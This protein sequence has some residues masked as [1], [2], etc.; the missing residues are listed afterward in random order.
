M[1][2]CATTEV[3]RIFPLATGSMPAG[4]PYLEEGLE[5]TQPYRTCCDPHSPQSWLSTEL[6]VSG[7]SC[8]WL[9]SLQWLQLAIEW[10]LGWANTFHSQ[11]RSIH[12]LFWLEMGVKL[13]IKN[14]IKNSILSRYCWHLYIF[15]KFLLQALKSSRGSIALILAIISSLGT[16]AQR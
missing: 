16:L 5:E 7:P 4:S 13:P 11:E 10:S 9:P 15:L 2:E 12:R 14:S 8:D 6:I 3:T 1:L